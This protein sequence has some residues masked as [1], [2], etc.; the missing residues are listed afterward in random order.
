MGILFKEF[1]H[2]FSKNIRYV[3]IAIILFGLGY[4]LMYIFS[5]VEIRFFVSKTASR[6][7]LHILPVTMFWIALAVNKRELAGDL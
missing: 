7:L 3:T 1:K 4:F 2:V 6:F 5:I